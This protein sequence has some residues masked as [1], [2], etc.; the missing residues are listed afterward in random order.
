MSLLDLARSA[1]P[2]RPV[3]GPR[4]RWQVSYAD[5]RAFDFCSVPEQD[6]QQIQARYPGAG[7]E[8]LPG[9]GPGRMAAPAEEAELRALVAAILADDTEA[10]RAEALSVA[11]VDPD[12]A[13]ACFRAMAGE[14]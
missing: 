7:V 12:A 9:D 4:Y 11:L 2:T 1:L 8:P 10:D 13:L 14:R 6:R 3:D 5:G